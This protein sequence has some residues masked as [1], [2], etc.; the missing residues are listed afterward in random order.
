VNRGREVF[1]PVVFGDDV[2]A[3]ADQL[4]EEEFY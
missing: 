3:L 1:E 4:D 2:D